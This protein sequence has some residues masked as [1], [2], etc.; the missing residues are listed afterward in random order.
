MRNQVR[1]SSHKYQGKTKPSVA[2]RGQAPDSGSKISLLPLDILA[3]KCGIAPGALST[4]G[5]ITLPAKVLKLI[6]KIA[7]S[8]SRL[9]ESSYL[10]L[11]PDLGTTTN[12]QKHFSELGYL[13]GRP[14]D[15]FDVDEDYYTRK[16]EDVGKAV[17][18]EIFTT[19]AE[20]FRKNG[21]LEFR[22]PR[23][24]LEPTMNAWREAFIR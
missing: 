4:D 17:T 14:T 6:L 24:D 20:H 11:N 16:Y 21:V 8:G 1:N 2:P 23:K 22:S 9:D 12:A 13:E 10:A 3:K 5:D 7:A 18:A 15:W 19:A